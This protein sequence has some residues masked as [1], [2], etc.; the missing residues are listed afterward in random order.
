MKI[1][2]CAD[3]HLGSKIEAKLSQD[4][5][6]MR[7]KEVRTAF[8]DMVECAKTEG[9]KV[10]MISGDLFD[11]DRPLQKDK[12]FFY[13]VVKNT[14]EIDFLYLR[15]NHD[16]KESYTVYDL[17]N[18]KTFGS[19]W[20]KYYYNNICISGIEIMPEN[21]I[22]MYSAL[23]L[24]DANVNIVMLHGYENIN[25]NNLKNKNIDYL[26]LGHLHTYKKERLD[27]RGFLAY[28]GCLEGRGFDE[29]GEKGY[30]LLDVDEKGT[31]QSQFIVNSRRIIEEN[32]VDVSDCNNPYE[33]YQ[34]IAKEIKIDSEN[35]YRIVLVGN[36]NFDVASS[37][38]DIE[39]Y[40]KNT[41][42]YIDIKDKTHKII[43][44]ENIKNE[45]SI[46]GEFVRTVLAKNEFSEELK[47][48]IIEMGLKA[49]SLQE[50]EI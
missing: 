44:I 6:N 36:V 32:T 26:A 39:S 5:A 33:I 3:I 50:V 23:N 25:L 4:K 10:I 40:L 17:A 42:F 43:N 46:R 1:I 24:N 12:E 21:E 19:S 20:G 30:I 34:K 48:N 38:K 41:C 16:S 28:S 7:K 8:A 13:S 49:L 29:L 37:Q 11:S 14:P 2:H 45:I 31:I 35:L 18:L 47:Q 27:S 9:V 22:S 15:G